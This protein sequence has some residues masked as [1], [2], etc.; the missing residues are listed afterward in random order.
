MTYSII[1]EFG[2]F[3]DIEICFEVLLNDGRKKIRIHVTRIVWSRQE[4][5]DQSYHQ[6]KDRPDEGVIHV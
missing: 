2:L 6:S 5:D 1:H 4:A 3:H